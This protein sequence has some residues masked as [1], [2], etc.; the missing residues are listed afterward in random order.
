M[1]S[2][3]VDNSR[4][5]RVVGYQITKGNF[6]TVT[7]NLPQ[8]IVILAEANEANQTALSLTPTPI[9]SA[10]QAGQL[11]GY[12][13]PIYSI[14]RI[15]F[16]YS[17]SGVGGVPVTVY[18]QAKAIGSTT[19]IIEITPIGTATA[20][21]THTL[22]IAGREGL[23][24]TFYDI[25]INVGDTP[26]IIGGKIQDTINGVLGSPVTALETGYNV[27]C[28]SKW[29]G[30]TADLLTISID[31]G[32]TSLGI[33]YNI[34][35]TQSASGTPSVAPALALFGN[36]W[37]TI[38]INSYSENTSVMT[39]LEQFNG[40]PLD[41]NPTGRYAS[42]IMK[43]FIALTGSVSENPSSITDA[44]LNDVTIAIC[45][46][47]LSTG[48]PFEAAANMA[49][50]FATVSQ[51]TPHLDVEGKPYPDMP[52]PST[53]GAMSDYNTRDSIVKKGCSTV[54]LESGQYVIQDFVTTY[55]PIGENPPQFRYCRNLMLDFN[56]RFSYY[57]LE[58]IN[59]VNHA[60]AADTD[61][62]SVG[63]V[64][65]PKQWIQLLQGLAEDLSSRALIV[66]TAF[67]Q[68][69]ITVNIGTSNPDRLETFFRY[70]RSG[71]VRIA[72]TTAQAGFNF[73]TLN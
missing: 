49:V 30:L 5:S 52:T 70:K 33:T 53:I 57:L 63:N 12:G 71:T 31:T 20:N 59:V 61:T 9:T 64:I 18:P 17:G 7:P 45:P 19:K 46:A 32:L 60:I 56:V 55:H 62:V 21:G 42:I 48:F 8:S 65:K 43:P 3:A 69:S 23:D 22:T 26:T 40:I 1:A 13:S 6:N 4:V 38:V 34:V 51:N 47:P 39:A 35:S 28:T 73:G 25:N 37:N 66:D 2:N 11:Y 24:G 15:L 16:P 27:F 68:S 36:I 14:C 29:S 54:D 67:M 10:Q 50:L 41:T 72:S 58:Q 44:R